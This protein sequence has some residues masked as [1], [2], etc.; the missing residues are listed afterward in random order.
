MVSAGHRDHSIRRRS[1]EMVEVRS[2]SEI[3]TTLDADGK[4][5]GMPFMPEMA[6]CC[7]R[8]FKVY[9]RADKT[10]VEGYRIRRLKDTLF[11]D[12]LRCDG[13][14]HDGCQRGCLIFWKT[15]WLKPALPVATEPSGDFATFVPDELHLPTTKNGRYCC[16]STELLAA[17]SPLSRWNLWYHVGDL[18]VGEATPRQ[19]M[20]IVWRMVCNH[21]RRLLGRELR[22]RERTS[23][24][25]T[26]SLTPGQWV[27]VKS[28]EEIE[29]TLNTDGT[30]RGLS[31]ELEMLEH[32]GRHYRVAF[33]IRRIISEQTG[34]M[35]QLNNTVVLEGVTCQ[36]TCAK[37]CPRS[38]FFYWR[39]IW[40]RRHSNPPD[41]ESC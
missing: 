10:C 1:G 4:L 5:D 21:L 16:Q 7:G 28:R 32:C 3:L 38:N 31:V 2:L 34:Q 22:G 11:L 23:P 20:R 41:G 12:G 25:G 40:L 18:F 17:T 26:L 33:P 37:N 19:F 15:A 30:N 9:R 29:A 35:I 36:G 27:E 6:T 39:E 14:R 13:Q 8:R 24:T